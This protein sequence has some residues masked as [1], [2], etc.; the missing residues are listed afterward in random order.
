MADTTDNKPGHSRTG[1]TLIGGTAVL[2]WATLALFTTLTGDIP[3]FQLTGMAFSVAFVLTCIVWG[4][5]GRAALQA[6]R[7]PWPVWLLGVGG[8]FGYHFFYFMALRNAPPV[9]AGL[10][11]YMWPLLIVVCSALLPGERLRWFHVAGA[12]AGLS[13]T[14]ILIS[15]GSLD[16]V[17]F[18]S[19]YTLGY[20]MA[21]V[22]AC[23]WTGYSLLSRRFDAVP[24]DTV[25][26]FCGITAFLAILCHL[27]FETTVWPSSMTP[28][29][30]VMAL[31]MGP[32]GLA[33]FTWDYGVKHGHIQALGASSYAAP[34]LSTVLLI[35]FGMGELTWAVG[36]ACF[37]IVGGAILASKDLLRKN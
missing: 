4:F 8:L 24:T 22:C 32:V 7:Q 10:I 11:A 18:K 16:G 13:G 1:A 19:E 2:M 26:G 34:L 14:V 31:G 6:L 9:E 12:V 36:V 35:V 20:V 23:T 25:G 17:G 30:A 29:L 3:P 21:I 5:R 15:G 37:L 27:A 28:W 33:F